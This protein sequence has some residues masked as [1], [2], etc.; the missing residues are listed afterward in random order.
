MAKRVSK[1]STTIPTCMR[2]KQS[3]RVCTCFPYFARSRSYA[4]V[5]PGP[6][7]IRVDNEGSRM[8]L[9]VEP[10]EVTTAS[11]LRAAIPTVLAWRDGLRDFQGWATP[12]SKLAEQLA[13]EHDRGS[14]YAALA[15]RLNAS[16]EA[17]LTEFFLASRGAGGPAPKREWGFGGQFAHSRALALLD[18]LGMKE[19]QAAAALR[20]GLDRITAGKSPVF[21]TPPIE[22]SRVREVVDYWRTRERNKRGGKN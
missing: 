20:E 2:C 13:A 3:P 14:S 15:R 16:L 9:V 7:V 4:A 21:T 18:A 12:G 22:R 11:D 5:L 8:S 6:V 10:F 19:A 17:H 1:R